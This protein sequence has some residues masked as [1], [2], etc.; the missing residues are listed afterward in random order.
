M[1]ESPA[2]LLELGASLLALAGAFFYFASGVA[3]LRLGD[4]YARLHAPTKAAT[5]GAVLLALA[6]LLHG[7]ATGAEVWQKELVIGA[8]L[9][10]T[11]PVSAPLLARAARLRPARREGRPPGSCPPVD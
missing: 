5:L 7:V 3:L 10:V 4:V 11:A 8:F 2:A 1:T 6:A 9:L